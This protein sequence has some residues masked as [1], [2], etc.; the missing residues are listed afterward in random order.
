M[1]GGAGVPQRRRPR[2]H[3]ARTGR[4]WSAPAGPRPTTTTRPGMAKVLAARR[5]R[6]AARR[7]AHRGLACVPPAVARVDADVGPPHRPRARTRRCAAFEVEPQRRPGTRGRRPATSCTAVGSVGEPELASFPRCS[8]WLNALRCAARSVGVTDLRLGL[9]RP[10]GG[11]ARGGSAMV[12]PRRGRRC[13][14]TAPFGGLTVVPNSVPRH[15]L[16]CAVGDLLELVVDGRLRDLGAVHRV[17]DGAPAD[18]RRGDGHPGDDDADHREHGDED[19]GKATAH[20]AAEASAGS[21]DRPESAPAAGR[22]S[23]WRPRRPVH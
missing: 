1:A 13:E 7:R 16:A 19:Q 15:V 22:R 5:G 12:Q 8:C 10:P 6:G 11:T 17:R 14:L 23:W 21:A 4:T 3:G 2:A 9:G 18:A 20:G